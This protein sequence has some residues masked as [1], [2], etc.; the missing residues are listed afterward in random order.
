MDALA[1]LTSK[2]Q[3]TVPKAVRDALEL[4]TG[5]NVH[6]RVEGDV[7]VLAKT[8]DLLDLAGSVQVP[9]QVR[10]RSWEELRDDAWAQQWREGDQG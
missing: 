4:H 5:D 3:I 2:G 7:V 9:P 1:R 10:G 8:P 6:F